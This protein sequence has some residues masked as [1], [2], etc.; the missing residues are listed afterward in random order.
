MFASVV[1]WS[2]GLLCFYRKDTR[3]HVNDLL[4]RDLGHPLLFIIQVSSPFSFHSLR[5]CTKLISMIGHS[6]KPSLLYLHSFMLTG[7]QQPDAFDP[8][9]SEHPTIYGSAKYAL[10]SDDWSPVSLC[11]TVQP[12][13]DLMLV[14]GLICPIAGSPALP[15]M[16]V[17][18][19]FC[20][21]TFKSLLAGI[22]ISSGKKIWPKFTH[23]IRSALFKLSHGL[24]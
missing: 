19:H 23:F 10:S 8:R 18:L 2:E 21:G 5:P 4:H 9:H 16:V 7:P 13:V 11:T 6:I 22:W 1:A 3:P 12:V 20:Y 24:I 14:I 15:C 17:D